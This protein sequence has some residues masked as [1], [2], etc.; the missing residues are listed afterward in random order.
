M[1]PGT[2]H[3]RRGGFRSRCPI[4]ILWQ[5]TGPLQS[6]VRC[7][8]G[9]VDCE[10]WLGWNETI[11]R[12]RNTSGAFAPRKVRMKPV[13]QRYL[14]CLGTTLALGCSFDRVPEGA[15][16]DAE[17]AAPDAAV[18]SVRDHSAPMEQDAGCDDDAA[19][20]QG[21]DRPD[22]GR[23]T[24][25]ACEPDAGGACEPD[26]DRRV[27]GD[28]GCGGVCGMCQAGAACSSTGICSCAAGCGPRTCGNDA[29]GGSCG[30]CAD[31]EICDDGTCQRICTP[32]CAGRQCGDDGCGGSC[33]SCREDRA[34]NEEGRC[35]RVR[36]D[37]EGPGGGGGQGNGR[38]GGED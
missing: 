31:D 23:C 30:T 36:E 17:D 6:T 29:C 18:A 28:D 3:G 15:H 13:G 7:S 8:W 19:T 14:F 27:C 22:G 4:G 25:Q 32:D 9:G 2:T 37:N 26:C 16:R 33:G 1:L 24:E 12:G 21:A 10:S 11:D 38:G 35:R 20:C 34:C 5:G